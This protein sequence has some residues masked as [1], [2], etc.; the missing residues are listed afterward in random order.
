MSQ[1]SIETKR[2]FILALHLVGAVAAVG[3]FLLGLWSVFSH[4]S[5]GFMLMGLGIVIGVL[6][7]RVPRGA[8]ERDARRQEADDG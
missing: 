5:R 3:S 6:F 1:G 2:Y 7:G 8:V 4:P